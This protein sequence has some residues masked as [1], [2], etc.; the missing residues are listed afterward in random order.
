[1]KFID[2]ESGMVATRVEGV[3]KEEL[4]LIGREFP[5]GKMKEALEMDGG[6]GSNVNGLNATVCLKVVRMVNLC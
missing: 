6:D 5:F 1:M 3:G 2:T 4:V